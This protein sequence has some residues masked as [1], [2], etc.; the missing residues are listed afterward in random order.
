MA[1]EL[2]PDLVQ[3]AYYHHYGGLRKEK[4]TG[5]IIHHAAGV[6]STQG[7]LNFMTGGSR[8]VSS[9]FVI[10]NDGLLG[11]SVPETHRPYTTSGYHDESNITVEVSNRSTGGEWFVSDAAL[12]K[13]IELVAYCASKYGW[14]PK[15]TGDTSGTIRYHGMYEATACPGPY[16][17]SKMKYIEQE[18]KK[19]I[20]GTA[21][22]APIDKTLWRVQ[23]GAFKN[24]QGALDLEKRLK[25]KGY[26]TYV[27]QYG[28][29]IKVQT[30]AFSVKTNALALEKRLKADGF[31]TY[32]TDKGGVKY[33][34]KEATTP[35]PVVRVGSIV[36]IRNGARD[37]NGG[38]LL[39]FVY[40]RDHR[41][42]ELSG[43]R[44]VITYGGVV[45]AA[46]NVRDLI[47]K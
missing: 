1:Y 46:V 15:F 45:V 9:T 38:T 26:N 33:V 39:D 20:A 31:E 3:Y 28:D 35:T 8:K 36:R 6:L 25:T 18:A 5:I 21:T 14:E 29:L 22:P 24:P 34:H 2:K 19:L 23:V 13:L 10:G 16:L 40:A 47:V 30:G 37:Y 41:V 17:K 27:V 12:R 42:S 7:L 43:S 44:A 4:I 32:V 11:L